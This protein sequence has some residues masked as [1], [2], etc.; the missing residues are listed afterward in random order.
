MQSTKKPQN[1]KL[2]LDAPPYE[3][4][5]SLS[6]VEVSDLAPSNCDMVV[7]LSHLKTQGHTFPEPLHLA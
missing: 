5:C 7:S 4:K 1:R 3:G 2:H 6:C